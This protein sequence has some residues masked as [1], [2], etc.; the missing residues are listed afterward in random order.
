MENLP[1][2]LVG[3]IGICVG[4][5]I[6]AVITVSLAQKLSKAEKMANKK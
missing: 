3:I 1:W 5:V 6:G 2:W 4:V